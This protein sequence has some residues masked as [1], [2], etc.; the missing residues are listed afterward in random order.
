MRL[1]LVDAYDSFT[2]NLAQAF[3]VLGAEVRV[4]PCDR[5]DAVGLAALSPDRLVFGPGPG[6]PE[7][8]GCFLDAIRTFAGRTPLLG[9]CL[10]HQAL[11]LAFGGAIRRFPPVHGRATPILHDGTDVFAGLPPG[12]PMG[13]YHSLGVDEDALPAALRV[14]ARAPDGAI[15]GLC[16]R[17]LPISGV[18]FHPESVMSGAPGLALLRNFTGAP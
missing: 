17:A 18:Q 11:A 4:V 14:T 8:A 16:H 13:R 6:R 7:Q 12:A 10:G 5:V 15:M 2:H 3:A 1:V 9:V